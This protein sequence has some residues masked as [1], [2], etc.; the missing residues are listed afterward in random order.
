MKNSIIAFGAVALLA[1]PQIVF[2]ARWNPFT[3]S[4]FSTK[5]ENSTPTVVQQATTATTSN[6]VSSVDVPKKAKPATTVSAPVTKAKPAPQSVQPST[7]VSQ[8]EPPK[9]TGTLCNGTYWSS[10]PT[11]QS[12]VCPATGG[13]YCQLPQQP[14]Q[15][16]D[17]YQICKDSY[18]HASWD[19]HSY[20]AQGGPNCSCD[21]G[22]SVGADGAS[23]VP[24]QSVQQV[25]TFDT[26][27]CDTAAKNLKNVQTQYANGIAGISTTGSADTAR[28]L[29]AVFTNQYSYELPVF[30]T[31][32][33]AA[34]YTPLPLSADCASSLQKFDAFQAQNPLSRL[35]SFGH[36]GD[37]IAMRFMPYQTDI[38]FACR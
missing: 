16:K 2:A 24:Q 37:S 32:A 4:I 12:L 15:Q 33:Q 25:S 7:P 20:T 5:S 27:A 22:Y 34:C 29:S 17:N 18:G 19:G 1:V 13:A 8:P 21:V 10:C 31:A 36:S 26:S 35:V 14:V 11:G 30:Q 23:C 38:Q 3:W 28:G 9:P 6:S